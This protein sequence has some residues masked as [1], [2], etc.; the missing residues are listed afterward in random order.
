MKSNELLWERQSEQ[1]S[2]ANGRESDGA[3]IVM[4]PFRLM[5]TM[6]NAMSNCGCLQFSTIFIYSPDAGSWWRIYGGFSRSAQMSHFSCKSRSQIT[7][8]A[9]V[10]RE[11]WPGA[12]DSSLSKATRDAIVFALPPSALR[13][14]RRHSSLA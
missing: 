5:K 7:T 3:L 12:P 8:K 11:L 2:P 14:F 1:A 13:S 10:F 4:I 9:Y 6:M